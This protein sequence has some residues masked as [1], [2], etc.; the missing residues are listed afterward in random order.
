MPDLYSDEPDESAAPEK[1]EKESEG[2]DDQTFLA[3]K[4]IFK[5]KSVGDKCQVEVV[6]EMDDEVRLKYV[7]HKPDK[8]PEPA[9][10]SKSE[11]ADY[12]D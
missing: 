10:E 1:A 9:K 6:G 3:P 4:S 12:M 2:S 5:G 11:M 8:K 7:P